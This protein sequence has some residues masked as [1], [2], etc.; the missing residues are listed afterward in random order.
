MQ[1]VVAV[2]F[3]F[4]FSFVPDQTTF[5]P[6]ETVLKCHRTTIPLLTGLRTFS[7]V[8]LSTLIV[9]AAPNQD[10][11][12]SL[13]H[14]QRNL[15][16]AHGFTRDSETFKS[17]LEVMTELTVEQRRNFLSFVTGATVLPRLG[18]AGLKPGVQVGLG[19]IGM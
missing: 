19:P 8:E 9:G 15:Q 16:P 12:W 1:Y 4:N 18:F 2:G 17:F 11:F 7:D 5:F 14:L 10:E 6:T 13:E 3:F